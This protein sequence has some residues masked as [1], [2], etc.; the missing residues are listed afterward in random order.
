LQIQNC[1]GNVR[2]KPRE[3]FLTIGS[4]SGRETGMLEVMIYEFES[5]RI[6]VGEQYNPLGSRGRL[7]PLPF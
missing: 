7:L 5:D 1:D 6:I 2:V 4:Q 3:S